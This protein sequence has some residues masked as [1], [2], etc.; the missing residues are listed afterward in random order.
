MVWKPHVTVAALCERES[1]FLL[2]E[3]RIGGRLC[4]NQPAGHLEP[5]EGLFDAVVRETREET[6]WEFAPQAL[7]G[8]YRWAQTESE[9]FLRFCFTGACLAHHPDEPLDEGIQAA[10]WLR[11]EELQRRAE[12]AR[13]PLVLRCVEDYLAG[14][15]FSLALLHDLD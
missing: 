6:G 10:V 14:Q 7:V 8:I 3:E 5:G 15:R 12:Q 2:V 13:S 11:Q 4:L 1:R 9:T